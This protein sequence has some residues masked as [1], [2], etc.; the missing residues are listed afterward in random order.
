MN[1]INSDIKHLL[2]RI[3][4]DK[5]HDL[6]LIALTW[7]SLI[8][9]ILSERSKIIKF[10]NNILMV[11]VSNHVW[12]QEFLINRPNIINKLREQTNIKIDNI[13]FII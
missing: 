10:E 7:K 11:K 2:Y 3:A 1:K 5:Y 4:G 8:G 9:E 12:L 6:V 13:L